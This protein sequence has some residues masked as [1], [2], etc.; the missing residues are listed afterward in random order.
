[1]GRTMDSQTVT[2]TT[3]MVFVPQ[4]EF[5]MGTSEEEAQTL[6]KEYR[7]HPGLILLESPKR[8]VNLKAF[9]IDRFPVTNRQFFEFATASGFFESRQYLQSEFVTGTVHPLPYFW[10]D[11][12]IPEGMEDHPIVD[13]PW[14]WAEAY[15]KWAGKRLPTAEEWEKAAR[16]TDGRL[17]PWGNEWND[18]ATHRRDAQAFM[19]PCL[20]ANNSSGM[21]AGMAEHRSY[22]LP[23]GCFP[24]GASPYGV[25]DLCGNVQEWTATSSTPAAEQG[26]IR[27][28]VV[29]G[30]SA[31]YTLKCFYRC[32]SVAFNDTQFVRG[33]KGFRCVKDA[34]EPPPK[35]YALC[36]LP[37][38]TVPVFPQPKVREDLYMKEPITFEAGPKI[39]VP[40]LPEGFAGLIAPEGVSIKAAESEAWSDLNA[41]PHTSTGWKVSENGTRAECETEFTERRISMR[42]VLEGHL[43]Y[44]DYKVTLTNRSANVVY[45]DTNT[46]Q[47]CS[48]LPYF[49]DPEDSRT[50][51][52][53]E[54]LSGLQRAIEFP[55][56]RFNAPLF[57]GWQVLPAV[58]TPGSVQA[59]L[60][61][62]CTASPDGRWV[63]A[64]GARHDGVGIAR[65]ANYSCL[66][67]TRQLP[68]FAP[69]MEHT[70]ETRYY[71][72]RGSEQDAL[73][74]W[75]K[76]R[77][78][79]TED[80]PAAK[81][82]FELQSTVVRPRAVARTQR[83]MHPAGAIGAGP[84]P[85]LLS[86]RG[87]SQL[88]LDF[89]EEVVGSVCVKVRSQ[90][91]ARVTLR[92]GENLQEALC[93]IP[94]DEPGY[95]L[96]QDD[97]DLAGGQA[98]LNHRGRRAFRYLRI[99]A[100][101]P[102]DVEVLD[103]AM[104]LRH[105][106]VQ[107]RGHFRCSD[108]RLNRIWDISA[109]TTRLCMQQFYED[110]IKR[111][112]L[113]W[114]GDYRVEYLC[115][116]AAFGDHA[117]ARKCLHM[118]AASQR[119][120]GAIPSCCSHGGGHQHPEGIAYMPAGIPHAC[121]ADWILL[122][123][124]GDFISS[125]KEYVWHSGDR[126]ILADLW[127]C[128]KRLAGFLMN[129]DMDQ[130]RAMDD[131][132]TDGFASL[133]ATIL[134]VLW[135]LGD[136]L[137]LAAWQGDASLEGPI[138]RWRRDMEAKVW[139]KFHD[140]ATGLF[141]EPSP[142][143][144]ESKTSWILN[145]YAVLAGL[146]KTSADAKALLQRVVATPN[147]TR[148]NC[149]WGRFW[150]LTAM[151]EN[152]LE[153]EAVDCIRRDWGQL[154]DCGL[155]TCIEGI[156][157]NM[158]DYFT[159]DEYK[160]IGSACHGWSAG[161]CYLLPT[162]VL[163]VRPEAIGYERIEIRPHLG[164]LPWA[165]GTLPTP[166]GDIFVR[167]E[168]TPDLCGQIFLPDSVSG[169]LTMPDGRPNVTLEPGWT[170]LTIDD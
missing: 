166:R 118:M 127:P 18:A 7:V 73:A 85:L 15:A 66:H 149:G 37:K 77:Y 69:G 115:N 28:Y 110:G 103:A 113:L 114:I 1:M 71:F 167:W 44:V 146:P 46:C 43:D 56:F 107:A 121:V 122:N 16:G 36:P 81:Q 57:R 116:T 61:F 50:F 92:Y 145:S 42:V 147:I 41:T 22:T 142:D 31:A 13:V 84:S 23:V 139:A 9:W 162:H 117:L 25:M 119:E 39:R 19:P 38:R 98:T 3:E 148:F 30:V 155:T 123:Y 125:V 163:G 106:P 152:G 17:Y 138:T 83:V 102:S 164:D 87:T 101:G 51:F 140:P 90:G 154:L 82:V 64:V 160:G 80:Y 137:T 54:T 109:R 153:Q 94:T 93:E 131:Y 144:G 96:P 65:N 52:A 104:T 62:V 12:K 24:D 130:A 48:H 120:D 40:Y 58:H 8:K 27:N 32:A 136:L 129:F 99:A 141:V 95:C 6:A 151:L 86:S 33:G 5:I 70:A 159:S 35:S 133:A 161:P 11:G 21:M 112:G 100:R 170:E 29:K 14:A 165:E 88:T 63:L 97:F 158:A 79:F 169:I 67:I 132:I 4:G 134:N 89:G 26:E 76:E 47:A 108:D 156:P 124:D 10:T 68:P 45:L 75:K 168:K 105:Y 55:P 143:G 126:K 72:L 150:T 60:P 74:R 91:P 135:G 34:A 20:P 78:P 128:L 2:T 111:D 59:R 157:D 49:Y 53:A